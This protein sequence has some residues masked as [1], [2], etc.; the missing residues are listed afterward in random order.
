MSYVDFFC[1]PLPKGNEET[2]RKQA[3]LFGSIM[4]DY[5]AISYCEAIADDVPRGKV[6]DFFRA[7]EAKD[8]ETVVAAFMVWPDK[9]T[10]DKAWE[11]GMKDPRMPQ[12][13]K[14]IPF[15]GMRMFW[16]GFKPI[17]QL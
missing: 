17:F 6:T 7:V 8:N 4:K 2:Y 16:G 13:P 3:E 9:A 1:L 10:R 12:N 11:L 5:G 14:D 15:D